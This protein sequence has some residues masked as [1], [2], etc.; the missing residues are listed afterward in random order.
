MTT[1]LVRAKP[2]RDLMVQLDNRLQSGKIL[3][4]KPFGKALQYG[5]Q[6]AK[7]DPGEGYAYSIED[8]C[9]PPL[10]MER[11]AILDQYFDDIGVEKLRKV[12]WDGK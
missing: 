10:A 3:Q 4:M 7:I 5:L 2:K 12:K 11:K 8:Y 6:N 1:Y 9:S